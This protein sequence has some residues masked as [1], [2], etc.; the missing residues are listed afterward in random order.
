[1]VRFIYASAGEIGAGGAGFKEAKIAREFPHPPF[2]H[3]LPL[4]MREKGNCSFFFR[5]F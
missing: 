1:M 2:G 3:L 4:K 5:F